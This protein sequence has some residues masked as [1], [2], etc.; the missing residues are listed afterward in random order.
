[1]TRNCNK[2]KTPF[3]IKRRRFKLCPKCRNFKE[4]DFG[5]KENFK[6]NFICFIDGMYINH[7]ETVKAV[8]VFDAARKGWNQFYINKPYADFT[9]WAVKKVIYV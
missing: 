3:L 9:M 2:C 8:D 7:F 6:V 4:Q 5:R 1:M